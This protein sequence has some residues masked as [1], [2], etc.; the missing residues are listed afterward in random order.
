MTTPPSVSL[1]GQVASDSLPRAMAVDL[2]PLPASSLAQVA[3]NPLPTVVDMT[4]PSV[5]LPGQVASD[6]LPMAATHKDDE[7]PYVA[8]REDVLNAYSFVPF[9]LEL[10]PITTLDDLRGHL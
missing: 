3:S 1:P 9:D 4:P 7:D 5:S 2:T 8:S 10:M 6:S